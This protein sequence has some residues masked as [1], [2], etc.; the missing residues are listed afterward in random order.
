[1][2]KSTNRTIGTRIATFTTLSALAFALASAVLV[3]FS[4]T[5]SPA[6]ACALLSG[7]FSVLSLAAS[8]ISRKNRQKPVSDGKNGKANGDCC[9]AQPEKVDIPAL[10]ENA[11]G[12]PAF[13]DAF[14]RIHEDMDVLQRS[15]A[16]FDLFSSDI[17]FSARHLAD[18][19]TGQLG[20]LGKLSDEVGRFYETQTQTKDELVVIRESMTENASRAELSARRAVEAKERLTGVL[21]A[22]RATAEEATKGRKDVARMDEATVRLTRVLHDLQANASQES[23]DAEKIAQSLKSIEDIV[24]RTHVLATNASIEAARAGKQGAGFAVIASEVRTLAA[25]S[26]DSLRAIDDVLKSVAKGIGESHSLVGIVSESAEAL[27]ETLTK[28][29][30]NFAGIVDAI[31]GANRDLEGFD[32]VFSEQIREASVTAEA[33]EKVN[34]RLDGFTDAF[35]KETE[36]YEAIVKSAGDAEEHSADAERA[37]K[38]LAQMAGY[39]KAGGVERN[40]VLRRYVVDREFR[41]RKYGRK[42][43]REE[44]L[45]NLETFGEDGRLLG[46]LGDLS[47]SGLLLIAS[48]EI[49]PGERH[50]MKIALPI[51]A[52]GESSVSVAATVR[53]VEQDGEWFLLGCSLDEGDSGTAARVYEKLAGLSLEGLSANA[54]SPEDF[55]AEPVVDA[56]DAEEMEEI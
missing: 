50:S 14:E 43:R 18:I 37:A 2:A 3:A 15:G 40:R 26:R 20:M 47:A 42:E 25:S 36:R 44:L 24:D 4:G 46:Y 11:C 13:R 48:R 6:M 32:G 22:S 45:Y 9:P 1:M 17:E 19:S 31:E 49:S 52:E 7:A 12:D 39:L 5:R 27:E 53:R 23:A 8:S 56:Y 33:A 55:L 28:T 51:T 10:A 54:Q 34:E 41:D 30:D 38:V 21:A 29:R 35:R 16:R